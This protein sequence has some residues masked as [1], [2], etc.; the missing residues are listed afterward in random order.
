MPAIRQANKPDAFPSMTDF[1]LD[2]ASHTAEDA[3]FDQ[4]L[5]FVS[6]EK[7]DEVLAQLDQPPQDH[8]GLRDLFSRPDHWD[9]A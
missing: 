5:F 1:I 9:K 7:Y 2:S 3:L 4:R 6:G 8:P